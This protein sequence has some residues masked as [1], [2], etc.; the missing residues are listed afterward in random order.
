RHAERINDGYTAAAIL[1]AE[2]PLGEATVASLRETVREA[3]APSAG[4]HRELT[5]AE[6]IVRA[7]GLRPGV[8]EASALAVL[9]LE[10]DPEAKDIIPELAATV[11]AGYSPARGWGDGRA[12]LVALEAVTR[13]FADPIPEGVAITL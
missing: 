1:A 9:A 8:V 11:L 4:G 7:D 5:V 2:L 6:G 13:L 10:G 3:I 12:N